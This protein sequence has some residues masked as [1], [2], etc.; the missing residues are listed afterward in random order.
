MKR[1]IL[2][3]GLFSSLFAGAQGKSR[4]VDFPKEEFAVVHLVD[5][6]KPVIIVQ[7]TSLRRF[8]AKDVFGWSC[9]LIMS[10][11]ETIE[12]GLPTSEESE[13]VY[14]YLEDLS[15]QIVGDTSY[16]NAL[17]LA[18]I[19]WNGT[20]EVIWQINNPEPVDMLLKGIIE[21]KSYPRDFDYKMEYDA[22]WKNVSLYTKKIKIKKQK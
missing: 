20:C 11:K 21:S 7:N 8:K 16:P 10:Y 12:N 18:R 14:N 1:I 3:M 4:H 13:L 2:I 17:Y 19:T 22:K 6:G 9:S 15:K 5:D